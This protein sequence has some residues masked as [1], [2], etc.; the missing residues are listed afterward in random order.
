MNNLKNHKIITAAL[1][2]FAGFIIQFIIELG[3]NIFLSLIIDFFSLVLSIL[4]IW[5]AIKAIRQKGLL[6]ILL[7]IPIILV[8]FFTAYFNFVLLLSFLI[9]RFMR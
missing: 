1:L 3:I 9:S 5:Q 4:G 6:N 2:V 7:A 8:G